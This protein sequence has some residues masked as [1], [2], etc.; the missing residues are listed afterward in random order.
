MSDNQP[1]KSLSADEIQ[2]L[3]FHLPALQDGTY[4]VQVEQTLET[5]SDKITGTHEAFFSVLGPRFSL[6][7]KE[8]YAVF[9]P[10]GSTGDHSNVLPHIA[11]K[12]ST[13]PWERNALPPLSGDEEHAFRALVDAVGEVGNFAKVDPGIT[14]RAKTALE[15]KRTPWLA[16][17]LFDEADPPPKPVLK[18]SEDVGAHLAPEIGHLADEKVTVIDVSVALLKDILPNKEELAHLCHVRQWYKELEDTK[19]LVVDG[20]RAIIMGNRLPRAGKQSTVHL[21]SLEDMYNENGLKDVV[22]QEGNPVSLVSLKSWQFS[23]LEDKGSFKGIL[24]D[25]NR[26]PSTLRLPL[27]VIQSGSETETAQRYVKMGYVPTS[28]QLRGGDRNVSWYRGPFVPGKTTEREEQHRL[29]AR[30]SDKL[31][32]LHQSNGMFEVSYAAAWE[33]GRMLMLQSKKVSVSLYHWKRAHAARSKDA[34]NHLKDEPSGIS[35]LLGHQQI[36]ELRNRVPDL[37]EAVR[38]WFKDLALLKNIPFNYL[39]PDEKMLPKES[40]RF[41]YVD[42]YWVECL[43]DGAFSIGRTSSHDVEREGVHEVAD[44]SYRSSGVSGFLMRSQV[45]A[46]WPDLQVDGYS[47]VIRDINLPGNSNEPRKVIRMDRL[48]PNVLICLFEGEVKTVDIHL[49]P[50]ALHAGVSRLDDEHLQP[51]YQ[52]GYYKELRGLTGEE[53][54]DGKTK[55]INVPSRAE[56]PLNSEG[57]ENNRVI[58][59]EQLFTDLHDG[60]DHFQPTIDGHSN[61]FTSAEFALEMVEGVQK[62]RFAIKPE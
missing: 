52:S 28:H 59:I 32:Q 14:S 15:K 17:L 7:P 53:E 5:G 22:G 51:D 41:F 8:V 45:V 10:A 6:D 12:R 62:V 20:E 61:P 47:K 18:N 2:F 13:L 29:P 4:H 40:I 16:L 37:P 27:N 48:S 42:A 1:K 49:K 35:N 36:T 50:E 25:L 31:L 46:G 44:Y 60:L 24:E 38:L 56:L 54:I 55:A 39:V 30:A 58:D 33:L 11:L 19:E 21:V 3:E 23:C 34:A 43:L 26:T 9:P 57:K